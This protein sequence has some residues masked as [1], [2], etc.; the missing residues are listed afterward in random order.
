MT[1][2]YASKYSTKIQERFTLGSLTGRAINNDYDFVGV[3]SVT[4]YSVPTV[5]MND[6]ALPTSEVGTLNRYGTPT[7]LQNTIQTLTMGQDRS[8][9]FTIDRRNYDETMMTLESGKALARQIDEV[10]IPEVDIYR[11]AKIVENAKTTATTP[12][13]SP[14]EAFLDG[15]TQL[16]EDKVPATG[17]FA[18]VSPAFFKQI[19]LDE[20][21]IKASDM[22]QDMLVKGV[23]GMIDGV[24]IIPIP[25]TYLP[26][27]VDFVITHSQ[28][29]VS[30]VKIQ[31]YRT[32]D[33]PPG[34]NGW[35][36]EGRIYYDAFIIKGRE[37]YIYVHRS[38]GATMSTPRVSV[39]K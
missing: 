36:V 18:Y 21:F 33:N 11:I 38:G 13:T 22:A 29:C 39:K 9:T 14:Y 32:H 26:S 4:I 37:M 23:M 30:P 7:E 31:D 17:R 25:T 34:I 3:N 6:Y 5:P 27:G 20:S 15:Q 24:P 19:K 2:N 35:L 12:I 28:A 1:I 16:F 8:F 10:I